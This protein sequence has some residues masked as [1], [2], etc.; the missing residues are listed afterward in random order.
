MLYRAGKLLLV[1]LASESEATEVEGSRV[2]VAFG[3]ETQ[4]Y[5]P[6]SSPGSDRVYHSMCKGI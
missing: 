4:K 6:D 2:R 5:L 1:L 3:L